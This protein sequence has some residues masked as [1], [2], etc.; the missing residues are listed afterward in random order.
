MQLSVLPVQ[1]ALHLAVVS[2]LFDVR[3]LS[4]NEEFKL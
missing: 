2:D 1:V 4:H 3:T